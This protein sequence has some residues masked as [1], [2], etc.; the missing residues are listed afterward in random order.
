MNKQF[1]RLSGT[2][3]LL[4]IIKDHNNKKK[5]T[6]GKIITIVYVMHGIGMTIK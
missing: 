2:G 4:A 6:C 5:N 1:H 3:C